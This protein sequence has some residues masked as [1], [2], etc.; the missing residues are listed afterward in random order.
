MLAYPAVAD[1]PPSVIADLARTDDVVDPFTLIMT[2]KPGPERLRTDMLTPETL[3]SI[4]AYLVTVPEF[5]EVI[6]GVVPRHIHKGVTDTS[7]ILAKRGP[8]FRQMDATT[9]RAEMMTFIND[10]LRAFQAQTVNDTRNHDN[11][12]ET[13]TKVQHDLT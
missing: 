2:T 13:T 12:S 8:E 11:D 9:L 5:K 7:G 4:A 6:F 1:T 10:A 3:C